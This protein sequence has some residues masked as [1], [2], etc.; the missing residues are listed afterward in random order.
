[1]MGRQDRDQLQLFYEFSLDEVVPPDHLLRRLNVFAGSVLAD[2]HEQLK[3]FYSDIGRPS[4]D[5]ELKR[6]GFRLI[7]FGI[8]K[9][10][11]F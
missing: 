5:P 6:D 3:P 2:L 1:M 7:R 10:A 11:F 9:S 4:I 8:P